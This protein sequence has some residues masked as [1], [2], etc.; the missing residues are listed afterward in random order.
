MFVTNLI[1][2]GVAPSKIQTATRHRSIDTLMIYAH[3]GDRE[4]DPAEAYVDYGEGG[5][6]LGT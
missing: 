5:A 2:H 6:T 3:D 4:R 1:R